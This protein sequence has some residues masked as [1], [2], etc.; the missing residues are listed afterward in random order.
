M[1]ILLAMIYLVALLFL[2]MFVAAV[3]NIYAYL[4][5]QKKY[6]T[7]VLSIFYALVVLISVVRMT[8]AIFFFYERKNQELIGYIIKPILKINL[9][10]VQCWMLVELSLRIQQSI[11]FTNMLK[12]QMNMNE[13]LIQSG[14]NAETYSRKEQER[15]EQVLK[16]GR[17]IVIATLICEIV[18]IVIYFT[19]LDIDYDD[20][21]YKRTIIKKWLKGTGIAFFVLAVLLSVCIV[22]LVNRLKKKRD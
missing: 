3:H 20:P 1:R 19:V 16:Y 22:W 18:G 15:T 21:E 2:S 10:I 11:K 14:K 4:I 7:W 8:Y 13:S 12:N 5:K 6:K 9:G 17:V